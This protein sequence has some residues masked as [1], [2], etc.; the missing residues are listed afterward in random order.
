MTHLEMPLEENINR[1]VPDEGTLEARTIEDAI[2]A[3]R[4]CFFYCFH[5]MGTCHRHHDLCLS[6]ARGLRTRTTT[7]NV[8]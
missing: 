7:L 4:C 3:L 6:P 8:G 5:L 2:S 1:I